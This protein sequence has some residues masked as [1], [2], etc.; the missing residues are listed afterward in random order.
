MKPSC[1]YRP[2]L[3]EMLHDTFPYFQDSPLAH[4]LSSCPPLPHSLSSCH[5]SA[6]HSPS[7][8][9]LLL[10]FISSCHP[11]AHSVS[12]CPPLPHS[13]VLIV[14]LHTPLSSCPPF[15]LSCPGAPCGVAGAYAAAPGLLLPVHHVQDVVYASHLP[16]F[17]LGKLPLQAKPWWVL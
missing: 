6:A 9:P 5:P 4:S 15:L 8:C 16:K 1:I 3:Q 10:H 13:L 12:S 11:S 14:H 7:S 17:Q 2:C